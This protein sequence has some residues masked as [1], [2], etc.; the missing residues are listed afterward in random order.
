MECT[1]KL[2][3]KKIQTAPYASRVAQRGAVGSPCH[4][5]LGLGVSYEAEDAVQGIPLPHMLLS[6]LGDENHT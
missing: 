1:G 3:Q 2:R 6:L 4:A 5:E